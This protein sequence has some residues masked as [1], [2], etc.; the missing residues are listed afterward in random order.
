MWQIG[1][2]CLDT[3][4]VHLYLSDL[5][6][7]DEEVYNQMIYTVWDM[8]QCPWV[9][10]SQ[11]LRGRENHCLGGVKQSKKNDPKDESSTV[12]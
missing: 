5:T 6:V 1:T 7:D 3:A 4:A 2:A 12:L 8:T 9:S 11:C 10:D